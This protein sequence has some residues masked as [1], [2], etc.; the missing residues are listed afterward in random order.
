MQ[1]MMATIL[2]PPR[3]Y[4]EYMLPGCYALFFRDP[5]GIK[6]EIVALNTTAQKYRGA[7]VSGWSLNATTLT[8][9]RRRVE[10]AQPGWLPMAALLVMV[11]SAANAQG[12]AVA[13]AQAVGFLGTWVIEMTEAMTGTQTV[14]IWERNGAV[15]ASIGG[16]KSPAIE[17]TGI[18]KDGNMLVL[19]ISRDG[20]RP[21][22]ENGVPIWAV[23][24][25]TLDGD[26][27]KMAVMLER[28]QTIKR[29][30]G[31]KQAD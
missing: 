4:P 15:A 10:M 31:K 14:R 23:Y 8:N 25:L 21:V 17:V 16:G 28:S 29:G 2:I 20:P 5:E 24:A 22:F 1:H 26:T 7:T 30:A 11:S 19:T 18:V 27:M 13:P 6:Y 12:S 9:R 3:E